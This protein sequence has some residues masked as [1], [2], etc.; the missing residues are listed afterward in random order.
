ML[1]KFFQDWASGQ[2]AFENECVHSSALICTRGVLS[3]RVMFGVGHVYPTG[4]SQFQ[5]AT[6]VTF[7]FFFICSILEEMLSHFGI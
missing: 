4:K 7:T 5:E 1:D 3:Y 6:V 2:N